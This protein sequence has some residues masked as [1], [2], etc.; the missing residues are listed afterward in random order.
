MGKLSKAL[1]ND[2][3]QG[4]PFTIELSGVKLNNGLNIYATGRIKRKQRPKTTKKF[5]AWA[6][7]LKRN[8]RICVSIQ[9]QHFEKDTEGVEDHIKETLGNVL[10]EGTV[11]AYITEHRVKKGS[12]KGDLSDRDSSILAHYDHPGI[13]IARKFEVLKYESDSEDSE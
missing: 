5:P 6:K 9:P 11:V 10:T 2:I 7:V 1:Q 12:D 13:F 4:V 3:E 8:E